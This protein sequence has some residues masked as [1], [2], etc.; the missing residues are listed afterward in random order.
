MGHPSQAGHSSRLLG[1][2]L[3]PPTPQWVSGGC[4]G[5]VTGHSVPA[6]A[7]TSGGP[8]AVLPRSAGSVLFVLVEHTLVF[9]LQPPRPRGAVPTSSGSLAVP[10]ASPLRDVSD[11]CPCHLRCWSET[12]RADA[13]TEAFPLQPMFSCPALGVMCHLLV[14][15]ATAQ[16]LS[17]PCPRTGTGDGGALRCGNP[18]AL[19]GHRRGQRPVRGEWPWGPACGKAHHPVPQGVPSPRTFRVRS[20][21]L[22]SNF[23]HF[24]KHPI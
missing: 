22:G 9:M 11:A 21:Q 6:G 4:P 3:S 8:R 1:L 7:A 15:A 16:P 24:R 23:F 14:P 2:C 10:A 19:Q 13:D 20:L 5:G 17:W 12:S 18:D